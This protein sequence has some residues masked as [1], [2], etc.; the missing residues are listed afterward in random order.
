MKLTNKQKR[1]IVKNDYNAIGKE[2]AENYSEIDYCKQYVDDFVKTLKGKNILDVGCGAG[3][4]TNYFCKLGFNA[5]GIDFSDS[6]LKIAKQNYPNVEFICADIVNYKTK[7]L[8]DGIVV[9]DML[10]HLPDQDILK[11]FNLFKKNLRPTSGKLCIIMDLPKEA[12]EHIFVEEL[13]ENYNIYYN[14]LTPTKLQSLLEQSKIM[15][16]NIEILEENNNASSYAS[17]LMIVHA[18][19]N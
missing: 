7:E 15:I 4:F 13:N 10:F 5:K 18:S 16:N 14:Y 17:R 11:V 6:L 12:G 19:V 3:K 8:Y 1:D 2:Y 9:K